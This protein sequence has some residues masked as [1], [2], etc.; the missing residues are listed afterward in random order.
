MVA[1]TKLEKHDHK[2]GS[3]SGP[4]AAVSFTIAPR[5]MRIRPFMKMDL[6]QCYWDTPT[7]LSWKTLT[8]QPASI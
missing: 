4:R 7:P 5:A 8:C 1:I 2:A 3:S 6:C